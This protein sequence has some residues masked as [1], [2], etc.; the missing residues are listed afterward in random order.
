M[1]HVLDPGMQ[2][3]ASETIFDESPGPPANGSL[4]REEMSVAFGERRTVTLCVRI[5]VA[6]H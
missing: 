3:Q 4:Q 2:R 6:N 5:L 1:W